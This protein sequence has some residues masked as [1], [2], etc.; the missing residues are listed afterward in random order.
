MISDKIKPLLTQLSIFFAQN[1][2]N[3]TRQFL[4]WKLEYLQK[5][6]FESKK[7]LYQTIFETLKDPQ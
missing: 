5:G 6:K 1:Q 3:V 7:P 2:A 4:S